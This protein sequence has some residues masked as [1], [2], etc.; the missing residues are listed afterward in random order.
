MIIAPQY[1]VNRN[2]VT[3]YVGDEDRGHRWGDARA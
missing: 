3:S 1:C 2:G